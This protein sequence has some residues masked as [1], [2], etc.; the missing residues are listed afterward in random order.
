MAVS[1]EIRD[2]QR[3]ALRRIMS[4]RRMSIAKAAMKLGVTK[5]FLARHVQGR[6]ILSP[7][8]ITRW[9]VTFDLT[10]PE[11]RNLLEHVAICEYRRA[12]EV[13]KPF[14]C[15]PLYRRKN[16]PVE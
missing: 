2:I 15:H 10:W 6:N 3:S 11:T 4:V 14:A 5:E 16:E 13:S 1:T 9:V 12:E 7:Y 8:W